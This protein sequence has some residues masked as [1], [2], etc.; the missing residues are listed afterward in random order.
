MKNTMMKITTVKMELKKE[1]ME[2]LVRVMDIPVREV[3]LIMKMRMTKMMK[4]MKPLPPKERTSEFY[5]L[6]SKR[7]AIGSLTLL[8][9]C[10]AQIHYK[11][12]AWWSRSKSIL[13][14]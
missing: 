14:N 1:T 3:V 7:L 6:K 10:L 5:I 9:E 11:L 2:K 13:V 12:S 8:I 4:T